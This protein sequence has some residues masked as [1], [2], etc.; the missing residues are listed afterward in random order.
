M[1][2]TILS[3]TRN[4]LSRKSGHSRFTFEDAEEVIVGGKQHQPPWR[5]LDGAADRA[6]QPRIERRL[7]EFDPPLA[8]GFVLRRLRHRDIITGTDPAHG[9]DV[10]DVEAA[11][12][13]ARRP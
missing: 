1:L 6:G 9:M 3:P 11:I 13:Q 4:S 12:P 8:G 7:A 2:T 10:I 5:G